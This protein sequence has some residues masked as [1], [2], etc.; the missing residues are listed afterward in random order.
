MQWILDPDAT[1]GIFAAAQALSTLPT[2]SK[3]SFGAQL[4]RRALGSSRGV[5][6]DRG[7]CSWRAPQGASAPGR[8]HGRDAPALR[9]AAWKVCQGVYDIKDLFMPA[10]C[11][12]SSL[13]NPLL[14]FRNVT[15][16]LSQCTVLPHFLSQI[17]PELCCPLVKWHCSSSQ[18][19]GGP[20]FPIISSMSKRSKL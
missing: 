19:H 18:R 2:R 1:H 10:S 13:L 17:V 3:V 20:F 6:E 15:C 4:G 14:P 16:H 8:G 7:F 5:Q 9:C 12:A 11:P